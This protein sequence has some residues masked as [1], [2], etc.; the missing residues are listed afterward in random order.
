VATPL[1]PNSNV[2]REKEALRGSQLTSTDIFSD[3]VGDSQMA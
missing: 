1:E 3:K 2:D